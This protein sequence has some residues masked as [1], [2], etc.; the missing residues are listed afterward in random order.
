[1]STNAMKRCLVGLLTLAALTAGRHPDSAGAAR[2]SGGPILVANMGN[3]VVGGARLSLRD[4]STRQRIRA[5]CP[6][7][8]RIES[9]GDFTPEELDGLTT[10]AAR[11]APRGPSAPQSVRA[12]CLLPAQIDPNGDFTPGATYVHF[13]R[14][15][16][17]RHPFP[18]LLLPGGGLSGAVFETTP[19][20]RPGW[21]SFFLRAG[22]SVFTADL[23]QTGR[24][25]FARYPEINQDEPAFRDRAF[26][27]EVFRIGPPGS[28][29]RGQRAFENTQFPVNAFDDFAKL[30]APRFWIPPEAEAEAYDAI[31]RRICPCIIIAHSASAGPAIAAAYR[32]AALVKAIVAVEPATMPT[33]PPGEPLPTLIVW[34]DHLRPDQTQADWETEREDSRRFAA[35]SSGDSRVAFIDLPAMGI[36]GNSHLLMADGNSDCVAQILEDWIRANA[37]PSSPAGLPARRIGRPREPFIPG[38]CRPMATMPPPGS[39]QRVSARR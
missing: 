18:I 4:L 9:G 26:F 23:Q 6:P 14:L 27:W 8:P 31:I 2:N 28:Y 25:P 35:T 33:R 21:E 24:S 36:S 3:I 5:T 30:A 16:A 12:A 39:P 17:P 22:Y 37:P 34:G 10:S 7:P 20:G 11:L 32:Q 13:V 1:M 19:D 29:D 38:S 15:A